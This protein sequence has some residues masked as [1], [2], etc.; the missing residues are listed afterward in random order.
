MANNLDPDEAR[1]LEELESSPGAPG[2]NADVAAR[3]F[4]RPL[5]F[6]PR[7]LQVLRRAVQG[8]LKQLEDQ[9]RSTLREPHT[10]NLL[11]ADEIHANGLFDD[12][13]LPVAMVRFR[14]GVQRGWIQWEVAPAIQT[15]E[16]V[17]GSA[18]VPEAIERTLSPVE[19]K[20]LNSILSM[21]TRGVAG[22]TGVRAE[23]FEVVR[24]L[25]DV[26]EWSDAGLRADPQRIFLTIGVEGPAGPSTIRLYL[27]GARPRRP[28]VDAERT[29]ESEPCPP[30]LSEIDLEVRALLGQTQVPLAELLE[31]GVGDVIPLDSRADQP[32]PLMVED[33]LLG[34]A[35]LGTK[36]GT[37][38]VEVEDL[39]EGPLQDGSPPGR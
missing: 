24:R 22:V 12:L 5:R 38:A 4:E 21:I 26:G 16:M 3:D 8:E 23:D 2:V 36:N 29:P 33:H 28:A 19:T 1:A 6:A 13:A 37:A 11:E 10:L 20:V 32:I 17:L 39:N 34:H 18:E 27:P 7:D 15:I 14:V 9:L 25:E 31:V 30:F 35:R